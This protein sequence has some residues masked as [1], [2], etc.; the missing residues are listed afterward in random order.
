M[1]SDIETIQMFIALGFVLQIMHI[2]VV[3]VECTSN[4]CLIINNSQ[5]DNE[6]KSAVSSCWF[7]QELNL[8]SIDLYVV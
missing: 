5:E 3:D 1:V 6:N 2:T 8:T 4:W 7:F